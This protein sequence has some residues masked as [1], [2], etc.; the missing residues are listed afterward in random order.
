MT[1]YGSPLLSR[2]NR[3]E[4]RAEEVAKNPTVFVTK[5]RAP[6]KKSEELS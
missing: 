2:G 1:V 5:A 3:A 6:G 4:G